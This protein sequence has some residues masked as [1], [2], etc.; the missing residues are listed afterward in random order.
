M[1]HAANRDEKGI[2]T[3]RRAIKTSADGDGRRK[4]QGV[5]AARVVDLVIALEAA[6]TRTGLQGS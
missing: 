5:K 6:I 3:S 1:I 4:I 2:C